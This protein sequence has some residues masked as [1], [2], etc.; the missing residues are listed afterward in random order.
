MLR[1][2]LLR[3][4][5]VGFQ[6]LAL[7]LSWADVTDCADEYTLRARVFLIAS[8]CVDG[9]VMGFRLRSYWLVRGYEK[10]E[11]E[12]VRHAFTAHTRRKPL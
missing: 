10:L 12:L 11:L 3:L 1:I 2:Q 4:P 6:V 7:V 5:V 9:A 8:C